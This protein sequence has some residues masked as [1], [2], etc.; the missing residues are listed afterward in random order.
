MKE[1]FQ[2]GSWE[3][4]WKFFLKCPFGF[5]S[6]YPDYYYPS[7]WVCGKIIIK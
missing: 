6:P 4:K 3:N 5:H 7:C 2:F 1:I